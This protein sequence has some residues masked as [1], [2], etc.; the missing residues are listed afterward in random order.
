MKITQWF[1]TQGQDSSSCIAAP[2]G[3]PLAVP[4]QADSIESPIVC[5]G[6]GPTRIEFPLNDEQAW[7]R[8]TF[9]SLDSI[10]VSR[11]ESTPFDIAWS[12]IQPCGWV[13]VVEES[14]W[15]QE[16]YKYEKQAYGDSY[17]FG[18]NVDEMLRDFR[19]YVFRF[20]DEFVEAI[21]A[22]IWIESSPT[23]I[24]N[25]ISSDNHPLTQLTND[26]ISERILAHGISCQVRRNPRPL[27]Q[28]VTDANFCSQK[29]F[30]FAA[31]L[32]GD[33]QVSW[34]LRIRLRGDTAI[35]QLCDYF[36]NVVEE[37]DYVPTLVEIR[38]YIERWMGEVSERRRAMGKSS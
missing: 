9:E 5:S 6:D 18:G 22:G 36:S 3:A 25:A 12:S 32:E 26:C 30:Q 21:A 28:L 4:F 37:F 27:E 29:L 23:R 38:P 16:R 31:E 7:G 1:R 13:A 11:G 8:I 2:V 24:G 10:R 17:N 20:H 19:H 33:A 14:P 35:S 34:T 15:L